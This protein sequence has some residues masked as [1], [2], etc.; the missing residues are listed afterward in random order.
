MCA[1]PLLYMGGAAVP[2][3]CTQSKL[4]YNIFIGITRDIK[5]KKQKEMYLLLFFILKTYASGSLHTSIHSTAFEYLYSSSRLSSI[6]LLPLPTAG[7][8]VSNRL[9][10]SS[11]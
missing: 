5:Y 11:R 9:R 3:V 4:L 6:A 1:R 10:L 2:P 7:N 8:T